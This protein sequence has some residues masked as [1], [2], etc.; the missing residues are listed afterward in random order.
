MRVLVEQLIQPDPGVL[1]PTDQPPEAGPP[2]VSLSDLQQWLGPWLGS[3]FVEMGAPAK[4][5]VAAIL[6]AQGDV[7]LAVRNGTFEGIID[8]GRAARHILSQLAERA[9][10]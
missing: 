10:A 7:A 2:W 8:V 4:E 1:E 9:G 5:Q 3:D 6:N